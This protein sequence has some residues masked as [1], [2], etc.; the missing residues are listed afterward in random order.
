MTA[1][2][3]EIAKD[4]GAGSLKNTALRVKRLSRASLTFTAAAAGKLTDQ[5]AALSAEV[6][7]ELWRSDSEMMNQNE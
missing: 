5:L 7:T 3:A 2:A 6:S 1:A 4:G